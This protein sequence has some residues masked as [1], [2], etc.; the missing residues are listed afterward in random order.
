M[1]QSLQGHTSIYRTST[2]RPPIMALVNDENTT[3]IDGI[4]EHSRYGSTLSGC[5]IS[6]EQSNESNFDTSTL[7]TLPSSIPSTRQSSFSSYIAT[8]N[9]APNITTAKTTATTT[10]AAATAAATANVATAIMDTP[11]IMSP[12]GCRVAAAGYA[13]PSD[14]VS[15][16][17]AGLRFLVSLDQHQ[18]EHDVRDTTRMQSRLLRL[19]LAARRLVQ[20]E[21]DYDRLHE[22]FRNERL[23]NFVTHY[24]RRCQGLEQAVAEQLYANLDLPLGQTI[25]GSLSPVLTGTF[26]DALTPSARRT[27][28]RFITYLRTNPATIAD[29]F[30]R[31]SDQ[32]LHNLLPNEDGGTT[33]QYGNLGGGSFGMGNNYANYN[34]MPSSPLA[35]PGSNSNSNNN[36]NS[37]N[38]SSNHGS[39]GNN[40]NGNGSSIYG[41][42]NQHNGSNTN[43]AQHSAGNVI[44]LLISG[45]YGSYDFASE[46]RFQLKLWTTVFVRLISERRG[47]RF[48]LDV[49]DR[50]V[51]RSG[52]SARGAL[53]TQLMKILRR[54]EEIVFDSH[55]RSPD[56]SSLAANNASSSN[57]PSRFRNITPSATDELDN[58]A[59]DAFFDHACEEILAVLDLYI[60][61]CLLALSR[62]VL[63]EL[64]SDL[65]QYAIILLLVK[66]FFFRFL[67]RAITYPEYYGMCDDYFISD[68]QRQGILFKTNQRLYRYATVVCSAAPGWE[69]IAINTR[70]RSLLERIISRFSC[71]PIDTDFFKPSDTSAI[72][73][74]LTGERSYQ[75]TCTADAPCAPAGLFTGVTPTLLVSPGDLLMLYEF[76]STGRMSRSQSRSPPNSSGHNSGASNGNSSHNSSNTHSVRRHYSFS[77]SSSSAAAAISA[78]DNREEFSLLFTQ[79]S[80]LLD[81]LRVRVNEPPA[82]LYVADNGSS[83]TIKDPQVALVNLMN[84]HLLS[85]LMPSLTP[86]STSSPM[87]HSTQAKWASSA[88]SSAAS[89]A[90]ASSL[91][92]GLGLASGSG[93]F[94]RQHHRDRSDVSTMSSNS[95]LS[96][97]IMIMHDD[98]DDEELPPDDDTAP[99]ELYTISAAVF[100]ALSTFDVYATFPGSNSSFSIKQFLEAAAQTASAR[101]DFAD[102]ITYQN[103]L[104]RMRQLPTGFI[105]N[106]VSSLDQS[107][108]LPPTKYND[109]TAL[110][111][112]MARRF[113][114]AAEKRAIRQQYR[115]AW[116]A[117]AQDKQRRIQELT[118]ARVYQFSSLRLRMFYTTFRGSR[119]YEKASRSIVDLSRKHTL[120]D[121]ESLELQGY[122]EMRHADNFVPGDDVFHQ[123]CREVE[124]LRDD[125]MQMIWISELFTREATLLGPPG[126]R[127]QISRQR[128]SSAAA[129]LM[130]RLPFGRSS[131]SNHNSGS[132]YSNSSTPSPI[133]ID[134]HTRSYSSSGFGGSSFTSLANSLWESST[135]RHSTNSGNAYASLLGDDFITIT[136]LKLVGLIMSEFHLLFRYSETDSWFN[137]L[138]GESAVESPVLRPAAEPVLP[139]TVTMT[140]TETR[141]CGIS[142][143]GGIRLA[144]ATTTTATTTAFATTNT[145]THR[146]GSIPIVLSQPMDSSNSS[147]NGTDDGFTTMAPPLFCTGL[148]RV[149]SVATLIPVSSS[150]HSPSSSTHSN[151][152]TR[153]S[154][155]RPSAS[156]ATT[157]SPDMPLAT[158]EE[159]EELER[160]C[161]RPMASRR[162]SCN[163][164]GLYPASTVDTT[165]NH[166]ANVVTPTRDDDD[167]QSGNDTTHLTFMAA[168]N[169]L[170]TQITLHPSPFRKLQ[171]LLAIN[172][173]ISARLAA[174]EAPGT[175]AIVNELVRVLRQIRPRYL[176]RD[177]QLVTTFVPETILTMTDAGK[178][179]V[180]ASVAVMSLKEEII[181]D[182]INRGR[183]LLGESVD[184]DGNVDASQQATTVMLARRNSM[185]D[186]ELQL[187]QLE[188]FRLFMI[189]AK[190]GNPEGERELAILYLTLPISPDYWRLEFDY[191]AATGSFG[192]GGSTSSTSGTTG[193]NT[194]TC[195]TSISSNSL[196]DQLCNN[197]TTGSS[198]LNT[199]HYFVSSANTSSTMI[200]TS[201]HIDHSNIGS[202]T[203]STGGSIYGNLGA[204]ASSASLLLSA[205]IADKHTE[206]YNVAN[207]AAAMKWFRRAAKKGDSVSIRYLEQQQYGG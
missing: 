147:G 91:S 76:M 11:V 78:I 22:L 194:F 62:S 140:A 182:V 40:H 90:A 101:G 181:H 177:L 119:V 122:L 159:E 103:A 105:A 183:R 168:C 84:T 1:C 192:N 27:C 36:N 59:A 146:T 143:S 175:D 170:C 80:T 71:A 189:A 202:A 102:S 54:G 116:W 51:R 173:L 33:G 9:V 165:S 32:E 178:A 117:Y 53:E 152:T 58:A 79:M 160:N 92:P 83:V 86:S 135:R 88:S 108:G 49:L 20:S 155:P 96:T 44:D 98:P 48:L 166:G 5:R 137:Q 186:R 64:S 193:S 161:P 97:S 94:R 188:A 138:V 89:A 72:Y 30:Y 38:N 3:V 85:P 123:F 42:G 131:S 115:N 167:T 110:I 198:S 4:N 57:L 15:P 172:L 43:F 25:P 68:K 185:D 129:V 7:A 120:T 35:S 169:A 112:F 171:S 107:K 195:N 63:S 104:D 46:Q 190:E 174:S 133:R 201:S 81:D 6:K 163:G 56:P 179:F 148:R 21:D 111:R 113:D 50:F 128:S 191:T 10:A 23:R 153:S 41:N 157:A 145:A 24:E 8:E 55:R 132:N 158:D 144:A 18:R 154:N 99:A 39:N 156:P 130:G 207:V 125:A 164:L 37:S 61:T 205:Q 47:E 26:L 77:Y 100:R 14:T 2:A 17:L 45:I 126:I 13:R 93:S 162:V 197:S 206:K 149:D 199:S 134:T 60:P 150:P 29:V 196:R 28:L 184:D 69:K 114:Y 176:C 139:S 73:L 74:G 87:N 70:I 127:A 141:P 16:T 109:D 31:A 52:W 75:L 118:T 66:F 82:L 12:D 19:H 67:G 142:A 121:A 124:R 187:R 95:S 65:R 203:G 106:Y 204:N 180:D 34:A 200:S 151:I 136:Q